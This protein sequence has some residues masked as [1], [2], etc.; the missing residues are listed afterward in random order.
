ME[1]SS[2]P[3]CDTGIAGLG[4][5]P[6][7]SHFCNFYRAQSDLAECLVPFFR[8]ALADNE[9]GIWIT[10]DPL[11]KREARRLLATRVSDLAAREASGQMLILDF[12]EWYL[13]T[14]G[15]VTAQ[16]LRAA[17]D[18]LAEAGRHGFAGVRMNGNSYWLERKYWTL[19]SE[20]EQKLHTAVRNSKIV[21]LCSYSLERCTASDVLQVMA[22]HDFALARN[23]KGWQRIESSTLKASS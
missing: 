22:H 19:F 11:D 7:G 2:G 10:S 13:D 12:A 8:K 18:R 6:W 20:Y 1:R 17:L 4:R 15:S 14:N 23:E 9:M 21:V 3:G 16:A 5:I